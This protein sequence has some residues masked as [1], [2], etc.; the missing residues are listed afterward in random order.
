MLSIQGRKINTG[1]DYFCSM[2]WHISIILLPSNGVTEGQNVPPPFEIGV[3]WGT[4]NDLV[5]NPLENNSGNFNT[6]AW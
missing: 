3:L 4:L 6:N 1:S 2:N 5:L